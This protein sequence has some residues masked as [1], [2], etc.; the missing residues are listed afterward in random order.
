MKR[1]LALLASFAALPAFAHGGHGAATEWH[2]HATDVW[3][4]LAVAGLAALAV[5]LSRG[6]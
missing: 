3:G 6:D 4:L 1:T 2:W 5:W